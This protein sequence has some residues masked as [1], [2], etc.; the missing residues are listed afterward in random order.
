LS[1]FIYNHER[2]V[3]SAEIEVTQMLKNKEIAF[4][5]HAFL[6]EGLSMQGPRAKTLFALLK[7]FYVVPLCIL[8]KP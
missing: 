2:L 4:G 1:L 7:D 8:A 3:L 5:K 6:R